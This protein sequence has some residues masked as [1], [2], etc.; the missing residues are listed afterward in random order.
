MGIEGLLGI[1][2]VVAV[3]FFS[4]LNDSDSTNTRSSSEDKRQL[5]ALNDG[6]GAV[7]ADGE[8]MTQQE[9][10]DAQSRGELYDIY[11]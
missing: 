11:H 6:N 7:F 5:D 10:K 9:A 8:H 2:A 1:I 3:F 4:F